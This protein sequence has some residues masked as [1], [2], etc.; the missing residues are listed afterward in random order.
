MRSHIQD[1]HAKPR[2]TPPNP[3]GSPQA[4]HDSIAGSPPLADLLEEA[5]IAQSL[6][7]LAG[8]S[9]VDVQERADYS[10]SELL[11]AG[12]LDE[13]TTILWQ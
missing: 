8:R 1:C 7:T 5:R 4:R 3:S 12:C 9:A 11:A 13:H 2:L 6:E 10:V